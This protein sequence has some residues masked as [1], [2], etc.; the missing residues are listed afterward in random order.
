[1]CHRN[2]SQIAKDLRTKN[3]YLTDYALSQLAYM[4]TEAIY[5]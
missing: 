2:K 4:C 1:M 3:I 5:G